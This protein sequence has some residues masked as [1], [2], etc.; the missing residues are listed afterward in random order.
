MHPHPN[1]TSHESV[2]EN[3]RRDSII[4]QF[5][6]ALQMASQY[7][8]LA[9]QAKQSAE[10][11]KVLEKDRVQLETGYR[12][13]IKKLKEEHQFDMSSLKIEIDWLKQHEASRV[14]KITD[15]LNYE[16]EQ[17]VATDAEESRALAR[18]EEL[19]MEVKKHELS[20]KRSEELLRRA[21]QEKGVC[22]LWRANG[23]KR[24]EV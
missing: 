1:G 8:M 12:T 22:C 19:E 2:V 14:Q 5:G 18:I 10:Q 17:R 6:G 21:E 23:D 7:E 15:E 16:Q 9:A 4:A 3:I 20:I 13:E 24:R 11:I